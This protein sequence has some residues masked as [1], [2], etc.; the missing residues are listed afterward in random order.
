MDAEGGAVSS[1][2]EFIPA[3][4]VVP[5]MLGKEDT[6]L[7]KDTKTKKSL[8]RT[9]RV[10]AAGLVCHALTGCSAPQRQ[11]MA[12]PEPAECPA[13]A[14][15]AMAKELA[16]PVGARA[17]ILFDS[18]QVNN[19]PVQEGLAHLEIDL[20]HG[21]W[22]GKSGI[23]VSGMLTLGRDRVYGRFTQARIQGGE[24]FPVCLELTD[25][26][27]GGRGVLIR[28]PGRSPDSVLIY[29]SEYVVAVKQFK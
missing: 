1:P 3:P 15:E 21:R 29:S 19:V 18:R 24:P 11:V 2:E 9:A 22:A 8:G 27:K 20:R 23:F 12:M 7:N 6:R 13:G 4:V 25:M 28:E 10:A 14:V 5:T 17:L 16:L 26:F